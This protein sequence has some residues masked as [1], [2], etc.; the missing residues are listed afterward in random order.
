MPHGDSE[1]S[2]ARRE[3]P[4]GGLPALDPAASLDA[5]QTGILITATDGRVVFANRAVERMLGVRPAE[6]IGRPLGEVLPPLAGAPEQLSLPP[7]ADAD[8]RT[9]RIEWRGARATT[10]DATISRCGGGLCVELRDVSE[11]L[12]RERELHDRGRETAF[13]RDVAR[14]MSA[15]SESGA[16]LQLLCDSARS[17]CGADG[18]SVALVRGDH[19]EVVAASG[20]TATSLGIWFPLAGSLSE[21][22]IASR[23]SITMEDYTSAYAEIVRIVPEFDAGPIVMT[24]LIAHDSVLGVLA[25]KRERGAP[26]FTRR[27]EEHLRDIADYASLVLWK[28]RLLEQAREASEAKSA[29]LTTISHEL[30]TP[31]TALTGYGEL[32]ADQILGPLNDQQCDMVERMRSVTHD[33][34]AMIEEILTY[35]SLEAGREIVKRSTVPAGDL[36]RAA[37]NVVEP[38][39]SQKGLE[40]Q[41]DVPAEPI[42]VTTDLDKVRQI[43]VNLAG[44]AVKFTKR[45]RVRLW[46]C[47]GGGH[48]T[49]GIEDTGAGIAAADFPR[50]FQPFSQLDAGLTREHGGTGLG[51]YISHRLAL[52]LGGRID[53]RSTEGRGSEFALILP[54]R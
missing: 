3:S 11:R 46:V 27:E 38:A 41:R 47:H 33:L 10:L 2:R 54:E 17:H 26:P 53:V 19:A 23:E 15:T 4:A 49:F 32:L 44:N 18:A 7:M 21:R 30:R 34:S 28:A 37:A 31:L 12:R 6:C 14:R 52:L 42:F 13:L 9:C 39:A 50:L 45:G 48:V 1:S 35:S 8:A 51:L 29:F 16:L 40:L 20:T 24:P 22:A 43:L 25:T 5:L 36:V